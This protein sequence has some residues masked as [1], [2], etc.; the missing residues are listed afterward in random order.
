MIIDMSQSAVN[1][2]AMYNIT[3]DI[4]NDLSDKRTGCQYFGEVSSGVP[5]VSGLKALHDKHIGAILTDPDSVAARTPTSRSPSHKAPRIYLDPLYTLFGGVNSDD[6]VMTLDLSVVTHPQWHNANVGRAYAA[7]FRLISAARPTMIAISQ[8]TSD[9]LYANFGFP[10]A[11]T[12]V[13]KLYTP[14]HFLDHEAVPIHT[15]F[16]YVLFVGSLEVRKNLVGAIQIFELSGL[17]RRGFKLLVVG[18]SGFREEEIRNAASG[19]EAIVFCG[20]L[21]DEELRSLYLGASAF[22][23]PSFLEG[24]GV[25][26]LEAM[27][28]GVPA[29]A[30]CSGALPEVG[31]D[32]MNYFNPDD[33]AGFAE[34][35][36]RLVGLTDAQRTLYAQT[37][38]HRANEVFSFANFS[39]AFRTAVGVAR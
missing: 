24:F 35:L 12:H 6:F 27:H 2:T 29:V 20:R 32:L 10:R 28:Y 17:A 13:A 4:F 31:G 9:S 18:G 1:K 7:A 8:N 30:S 33:H 19:L 16:P 25:P 37:A 23:Y 36:R 26:L 11:K 15:P 22:L 38:K 3:M 5:S 34:D 39:K 14:K 21:S